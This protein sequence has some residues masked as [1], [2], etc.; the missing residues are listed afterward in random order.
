[1][2]HAEIASIVKEACLLI[3]CLAMDVI[4]LLDLAPAEMCL[5]SRCLAMVLYV[6]LVAIHMATNV[7]M[8]K[9][10]WMETYWN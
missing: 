8:E 5:L 1:M 6:T 10:P 2:D 9:L 3:R 7:Y 4:L